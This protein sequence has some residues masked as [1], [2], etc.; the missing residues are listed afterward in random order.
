M[1]DAVDRAV[2]RALNGALKGA[3]DKTVKRAVNRVL[4]KAFIIHIS[5]PMRSIPNK[6]NE[7]QNRLELN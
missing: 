1:N 2:K 5:A 4:S 3:V 7:A 6:I